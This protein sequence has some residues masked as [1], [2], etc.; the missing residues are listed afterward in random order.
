MSTKIINFIPKSI[1]LNKEPYVLLPL[2]KWQEFEDIYEDYLMA[3]SPK[4]Q[5]E[6]AET[7]EEIKR[8]DYITLEEYHRKR[9]NKNV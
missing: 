5:K 2:K 7:E 9:K 4:L 6:L 3:N 8:G 1:K